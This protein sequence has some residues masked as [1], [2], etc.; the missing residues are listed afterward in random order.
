[1]DPIRLPF[2]L[3]GSTPERDDMKHLTKNQEIKEGLVDYKEEQKERKESERLQTEVDAQTALF[4]ADITRAEEEVRREEAFQS[5]MS[6]EVDDAFDAFVD[7]EDED[8]YD[9]YPWP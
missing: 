2:H 9:E 5:I 3:I 6:H 7:T 8:E 4:F 1:M